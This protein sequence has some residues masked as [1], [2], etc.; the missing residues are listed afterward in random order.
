[1][2]LERTEVE[3]ERVRRDPLIELME[4]KRETTE[5]KEKV[6]RET[7]WDFSGAKKKVPQENHP[8]VIR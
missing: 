1:M 5:A 2:Q 3:D 4:M 8:E 7:P 6:P